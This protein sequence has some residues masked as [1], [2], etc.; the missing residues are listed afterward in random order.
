[1]TCGACTLI[2][3]RIFRT[4]G[5][6]CMGRRRLGGVCD[7]IARVCVNNVSI[8]LYFLARLS[9]PDKTIIIWNLIS[10]KTNYGTAKRSLHGH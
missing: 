6:Q 7:R 2:R 4:I 8:E 10:D 1:M 3:V 9:L 5:A